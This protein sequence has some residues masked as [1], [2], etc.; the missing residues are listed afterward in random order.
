MN[1][2]HVREKA[3]KRQIK[4]YG[5]LIKKLFNQQKGGENAR[6]SAKSCSLANYHLVRVTRKYYLSYKLLSNVQYVSA[7]CTQLCPTHN[8]IYHTK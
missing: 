5:C 2:H 3:N 6:R 8:N 7:D 4:R 1:D